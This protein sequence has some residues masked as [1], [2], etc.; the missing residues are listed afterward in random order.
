M[1]EILRPGV[2]LAVRF[3]PEGGLGLLRLEVE[4]GATEED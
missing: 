1:E 4:L 3:Q 2:P